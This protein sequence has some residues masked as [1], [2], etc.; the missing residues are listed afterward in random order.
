M[1]A[2]KQILSTAFLST[3]LAATAAPRA[4]LA[5]AAPVILEHKGLCTS[6][7]L[8]TGQME[9]YGIVEPSGHAHARVPTRLIVSEDTLRNQHRALSLNFAELS[10]NPN[11]RGSR[12]DTFLRLQLTEL[13]KA[14]GDINNHRQTGAPV[15]S[16]CGPSV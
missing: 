5:P 12:F 14:I 13:N 8:K 7:N 10:Q 6:G 16:L 15:L 2:M 11:A 9:Y 1:M 3:A 4:P